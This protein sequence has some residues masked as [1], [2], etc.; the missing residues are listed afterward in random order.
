MNMA[1]LAPIV[2]FGR[3][4]TSLLRGKFLLRKIENE[5]QKCLLQNF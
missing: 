4:I 1:R 5:E 2:P 3:F